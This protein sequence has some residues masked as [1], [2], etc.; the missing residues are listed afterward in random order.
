M[1]IQHGTRLLVIENR[2][3]RDPIRYD[4]FAR[5]VV[6]GG[7][8]AVLIVQSIDREAADQFL[9]DTYAAIVH[10]EVLSK[11]ERYASRPEV[12]VS[13]YLGRSADRSL[14]LTGWIKDMRRD[15]AQLRRSIKDPQL[16][17]LIR[18]LRDDPMLQRALRRIDGTIDRSAMRSVKD[19]LHSAGASPLFSRLKATVDHVATLAASIPPAPWNHEREGIIPLA[20]AHAALW[21]AEEEVHDLLWKAIRNAPRVLN[22]N[23]GTS[24][25]MLGKNEPLVAGDDCE[26]FV[27]VGPCWKDDNSIVRGSAEFP[28]ESLPPAPEGHRIEVVFSSADFV[29]PVSRADLWLP[30]G[31]GRSSPMIEEQPS[32]EPGP[33]ILPLRVRGDFPRTQRRSRQRLHGRL[34]LY[35][36]N[37]LLQSANISVALARSRGEK[38]DA[39]G[40]SKA[41]NQINVDFRITGTYRDIGQ[42]F[43]HRRFGDDD[44]REV[45]LNITLNAD[46]GGNH[47]ILVKA[48]Q[49]QSPAWLPYDPAALKDILTR[50]RTELVILPGIRQF[51]LS[52][53]G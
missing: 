7:G 53:Y 41:R 51:E 23:F 18:Y 5:Q 20:E 36:K 9:A 13:L 3:T 1:G 52:K 27:D 47:R 28:T 21:S 2:N 34:C 45:G 44:V 29:P 50:C 8:P 26:L 40:K 42:K 19:Y 22:A 38:L 32:D 46:G 11:V 25:G 37:N 24:A 12:E 43:S 49:A 15:L 17:T 39:E 4:R 10:G 16:Y 30:S 35:H 31:F 14:M 33:V 6:G 48:G